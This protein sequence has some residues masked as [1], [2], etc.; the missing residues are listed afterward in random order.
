MDFNV[1]GHSVCWWCLSCWDDWLITNIVL[2]WYQ[3][4]I[5]VWSGGMEPVKHCLRGWDISR[6]PSWWFPSSDCE[7]WEACPLWSRA[8]ALCWAACGIFYI[9]QWYSSLTLERGEGSGFSWLCL[10]EN[11][12]RTRDIII[13]SYG[14]H[15]LYTVLGI[16]C[17]NY[18]AW[19]V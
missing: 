18:T 9:L 1:A 15:K 12:V 14:E 8:S 4:S 16:T 19:L 11:G 5:S 17:H 10:G 13:L 7:G 6:S 3:K 2:F